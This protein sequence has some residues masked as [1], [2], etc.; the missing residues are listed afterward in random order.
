MRTLAEIIIANHYGWNQEKVSEPAFG[1]LRE[2]AK[3][4][5]WDEMTVLLQG[6]A[7]THKKSEL[8]YVV[9]H[10][11]GV[12]LSNYIYNNTVANQATV[13]EYFR[14]EKVLASITD[15]AYVDGQLSLAVSKIMSDL[16]E[17][18]AKT[19]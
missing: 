11:S 4:N 9:N 17:L 8:A 12:L 3:D 6:Y 18:A 1:G 16:E 7:H 13:D 19:N 10:L 14:N 5:R 2:L 15:A